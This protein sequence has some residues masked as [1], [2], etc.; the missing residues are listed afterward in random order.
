MRLRPGRYPYDA[1]QPQRPSDLVLQ[2]N[3]GPLFTIWNRA[4]PPA[5]QVHGDGA[6]CNDGLKRRAETAGT[7][8]LRFKRRITPGIKLFDHRLPLLVQ[9]WRSCSHEDVES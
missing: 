4:A 1:V 8:G 6:L 7:W 3:L 2:G 9:V 5:D